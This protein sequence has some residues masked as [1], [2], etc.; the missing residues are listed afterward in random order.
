MQPETALCYACKG[1]HPLGPADID[2]ATSLRINTQMMQASELH[3]HPWWYVPDQLAVGQNNL[4][5]P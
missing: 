2:T 3:T 1:Y 5:L 4:Q